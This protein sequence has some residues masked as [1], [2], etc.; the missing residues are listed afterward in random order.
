MEYLFGLFGKRLNTSR[1]SEEQYTIG[2]ICAHDK[3]MLAAQC[4]LDENHGEINGPHPNDPNMYILGR[5]SEHNVVLYNIPIER[6]VHFAATAFNHMLATF[7]NL[8]CNVLLGTGAGVPSQ[9]NDIR[10]GDVVVGVPDTKDGGLVQHQASN[11]IE[12]GGHELTGSPTHFPDFMLNALLAVESYH[13]AM[14]SKIPKFLD[15][16]IERHPEMKARGY[17]YDQTRLD[18]GGR[19]IPRYVRPNAA[20]IVHRGRIA[21]GSQ[22]CIKDGQSIDYWGDERNVLCFEKEGAY[23]TS[24]VPSVSIRGISKYCDSQEDTDWEEYAAAVAAGFAK[25]LLTAVM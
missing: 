4:L 21:A 12:S 11:V 22:V 18:I 24:R 13:E 19:K 20:P 2:I 3:E 6:G 17:G 14:G 25:E 23:P 5:L 16:M 10:L 8:K 1:L 9:K 7:R 15:E